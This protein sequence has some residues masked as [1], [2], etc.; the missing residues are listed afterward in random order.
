MIA[1]MI[2]RRTNKRFHHRLTLFAV[3]HGGVQAAPQ[4]FAQGLRDHQPLALKT[5]HHPVRQGSD[6]HFCRD[7]LDQQQSVIHAFQR[8]VNARWLQEVTPDIKA[9]ALHRINQ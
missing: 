3:A 1:G 9:A 8:W 5:L 4:P 2:A 6:A 7:H